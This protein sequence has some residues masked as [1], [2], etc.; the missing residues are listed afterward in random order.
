MSS[1]SSSPSPSS[2]SSPRIPFY[3][4]VSNVAKKANVGNMMRS[5]C[6]FGVEEILI[7]GQKKNLQYFGA[8]GTN[9]HVK[10]R[11]FDKLDA[12]CAFAKERGCHIVGIE[13][14]DKAE[15][16]AGHPFR[17][18]TAFLL[19][20]EGVGLSDRDIAACDHFVY[21]PQHGGGTASLNVTVA[22][23]IV[24]HH[25]SLWAGYSERAREGYKYVVDEV[26]QQKGAVS[27]EQLELSVTRKRRKLAKIAELESTIAAAE[28]DGAQEGGAAA[29]GDG[30]AAAAAPA[31]GGSGK[32]SSDLALIA[33]K[34]TILAELAEA[35]ARLR[36]HLRQEEKGS[37]SSA[38]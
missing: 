31:A 20:N 34:G 32:N 36:E 23:S 17:G 1:S 29:A 25:F 11:C 6:A 18:P 15:N 16:V 27:T 35:E 8:Q 37:G 24:F 10:T 3:V 9:K 13:I 12:A 4:I 26:P 22:A 30:A 2:S 38:P 21:I 14:I 7:V 33:S 5:A 28:A 19:G